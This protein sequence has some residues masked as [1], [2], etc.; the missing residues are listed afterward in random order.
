MATESYAGGWPVESCW[1]DRDGTGERNWNR[2][3]DRGRVEVALAGP[4]LGVA[5]L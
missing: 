3:I 4:P 5:G 2:V 1:L